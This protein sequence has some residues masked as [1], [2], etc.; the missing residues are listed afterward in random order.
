MST[1]ITTPPPIGSEGPWPLYRIS[2]DQYQAMVDSDI[3]TERDRLQWTEGQTGGGRPGCRTAR[4]CRLP[5]VGGPSRP[6]RPGW[7]PALATRSVRC[8]PG[9]QPAPSG[10]F[11]GTAWTRGRG[12][13][14]ARAKRAAPSPG[15]L[16][17]RLARARP[18]VRT[19]R[20]YARKVDRSRGSSQSTTGTP[21]VIPP[22]LRPL[23]LR[24]RSSGTPSAGYAAARR[25]TGLEAPPTTTGPAPPPY[26]ATAEQHQHAAH[27]ARGQGIGR[28]RTARR[29]SVSLR[30]ASSRIAPRCGMACCNRVKNA[31]P[32]R[33]AEHAASQCLSFAS[34]ENQSVVSTSNETG[35]RLPEGRSSCPAVLRDFRPALRPP[36]PSVLRPHHLT[37]RVSAT[38]I[39]LRDSQGSRARRNGHAAGTPAVIAWRTHAVGATGCATLR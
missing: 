18:L 24:S 34:P 9:G 16:V 30:Q 7:R 33:P 8:P 4:G 20:L 35:I 23:G 15:R 21:R 14:S 37:L 2:V 5:P 17:P 1:F 36:R 13:Q 19:Y 25:S 39:S 11:V 26:P 6:N 22:D 27:P 38:H 12:L 10:A 28:R 29:K 3:F 32:V 31:R